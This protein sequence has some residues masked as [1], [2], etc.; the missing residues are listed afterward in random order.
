MDIIA[1]T[2]SKSKTMD[3][4]FQIEHQVNLITKNSDQILLKENKLNF[5]LLQDIIKLT[6]VLSRS[7][8]I[9]KYRTPRF[10]DFNRSVP[11]FYNKNKKLN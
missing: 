5:I 6:M 9:I 8:F 11:H 7:N 3:N 4:T 1:I 2:N 10:Y